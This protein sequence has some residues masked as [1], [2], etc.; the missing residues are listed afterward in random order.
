MQSVAVTT[1][2]MSRWNVSHKQRQMHHVRAQWGREG[3]VLGMGLICLLGQVL[4]G[5]VAD[6]INLMLHATPPSNFTGHWE[7]V[8]D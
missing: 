2:S 4:R 1:S 7:H 5:A 6:T 8:T 3:Y